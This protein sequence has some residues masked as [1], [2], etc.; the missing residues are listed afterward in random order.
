MSGLSVLILLITLW[1]LNARLTRI[2][3][4]L[5]EKNGNEKQEKV[6]KTKAR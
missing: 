6:K 2:A 3:E 5:E 1:S 4:A